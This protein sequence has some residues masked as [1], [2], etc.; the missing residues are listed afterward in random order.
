MIVGHDGRAQLEV[1][2]GERLDRQRDLLLDEA[3][4]LQHARAQRLE[5]G[6]ELL[7]RVGVF[8]HLA[9]LRSCCPAG[10]PTVQPF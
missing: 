4:H 8:G 5:L 9:P 6:I 7:G 3:A 10:S 2:A 1:A